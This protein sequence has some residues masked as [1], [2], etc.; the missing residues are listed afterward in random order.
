M[1]ADVIQG[2]PDS[3]SWLAEACP[4]AVPAVCLLTC[5]KMEY[6]AS[7]SGRPVARWR[8]AR[9]R[10]STSSVLLED[11]PSLAVRSR[12]ASHSSVLSSEKIRCLRVEQASG[13]QA[14]RKEGTP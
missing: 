2:L 6:L 11:P 3:A 14:G 5:A 12:A 4:C 8:A 7:T 13:R 9:L 1:P 10:L